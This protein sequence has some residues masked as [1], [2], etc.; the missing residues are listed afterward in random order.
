MDVPEELEVKVRAAAEGDAVDVALRVNGVEAGRFLAGPEWAE[1]RVRVP[2]A[3]WR[4][5]LNDVVLA[6]ESGSLRVDAIEL[7]QLTE[8][9]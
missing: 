4:R 9:R 3:F 6:P 2:S 5:E 8:K 1:H 7:A